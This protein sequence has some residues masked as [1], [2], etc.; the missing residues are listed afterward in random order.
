MSTSE[1]YWARA[2]AKDKWHQAIREHRIYPDDPVA[3][4]RRIRRRVARR[5]CGHGTLGADDVVALESVERQLE[6][7]LA[8]KKG[9]KT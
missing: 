8:E 4:L 2:A 9:R 5:V 1:A 6:Q 7:L 3:E